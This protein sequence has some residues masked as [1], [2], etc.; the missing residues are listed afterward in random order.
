MTPNLSRPQLYC[1]M[2]LAL[3]IGFATESAVAQRQ[4]PQ[5]KD[6]AVTE[7]YTGAN[8]RLILTEEHKRFRTRLEAARKMRPNFAGHY[9]VTTWGCG[10]GCLL[11]AVI[12]ARTGK[13]Y[14]WDFSICCW[15]SIADDNFNPIEFRLNSRLIV[16]SGARNEEE[17][18]T[19]AHFY[20]FENGRLVHLRSILEPQQ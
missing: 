6:F 14:Q 19:G 10:S 11:G 3:A 7:T 5:F 9:I 2:L 16:F 15:D 20:K 4:V 17:G 18:D 13:V 8:A 12:D 1:G